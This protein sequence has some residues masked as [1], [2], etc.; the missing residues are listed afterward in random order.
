VRFE[1]A[2]VHVLA[3]GFTKAELLRIAEGGHECDAVSTILRCAST[4]RFDVVGAMRARIASEDMLALLD[5]AQFDARRIAP[6]TFS[7]ETMRAFVV[8]RIEIV[9]GFAHEVCLTSTTAIARD[10][11]FLDAIFR[12]R[13]L[14]AGYFD[15]KK[16]TN[17]FL[18][19]TSENGTAVVLLQD[20]VFLNELARREVFIT[21]DD[22]KAAKIPIPL[23][24]RA[25][26]R[27]YG[28]AKCFREQMSRPPSE[29]AMKELSSWEFDGVG[30][31]RSVLLGMAF[32]SF[33]MF[34]VD[35]YLDS[36]RV[37]SHAVEFQWGVPLLLRRD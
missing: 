32:R 14:Y 24:N 33:S 31:P 7:A 12:G 3:F 22:V 30:V 10:R 17:R 4:K 28:A 2:V 35:N 6:A 5:S 23:A 19:I 8:Q 37:W 29:L 18:S 36:K 16:G 21:D 34:F 9:P 26:P 27:T 25:R 15:Q 11:A 13:N 1:H 20:D